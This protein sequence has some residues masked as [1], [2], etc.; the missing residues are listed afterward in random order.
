MFCFFFFKQKTAYEMRIS[1]W[2]S[3]VCSSDLVLERVADGVT[4]DRGLVGR[5]SLAT[6]VAVLDQLLGVVPGTTSVGEEDR[7]QGAGPDRAGEEAGQWPDTETEP[8][9]DRR[10]DRQD[11]GCGQLAQGVLGDD[12]DDLAI[13]GTTRSL[14]DS[15]NPADMTAYPIDHRPRGPPTGVDG[16][17]GDEG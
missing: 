7:H 11:A 9:S 2:S 14:P 6:V 12:V 13:F 5:R 15:G 17:D 16:E 3:D 4:D 8:D 1:D 10:Q